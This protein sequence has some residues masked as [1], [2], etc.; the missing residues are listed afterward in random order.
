M[1]AEPRDTERLTI[2]KLT[3]NLG[4][5]YPNVANHLQKVYIV[6]TGFKW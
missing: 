6:W 1:G 2:I 5:G 4:V 3:F